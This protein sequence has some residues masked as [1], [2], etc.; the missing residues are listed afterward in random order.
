MRLR[1]DRQIHTQTDT[2]DVLN[3]ILRHRCCVTMVKNGGKNTKYTKHR[4]L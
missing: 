4:K 3:A 1:T 2:Q